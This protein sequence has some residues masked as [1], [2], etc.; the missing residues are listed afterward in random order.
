MILFLL[1]KLNCITETKQY[2]K[3]KPFAKFP[4]KFY[5]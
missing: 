5:W 3:N 1:K 4:E 2:E